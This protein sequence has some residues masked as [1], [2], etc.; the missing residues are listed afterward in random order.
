MEPQLSFPSFSLAGR[1]AL[2]TGAARGIG[3]AL[4]LGLAQAGAQVAVTDLNEADLQNVVAEIEALGGSTLAR[5][6]DVRQVSTIGPAFEACGHA[7]GGL[8]I[9][10]N[11]AGIEKVCDSL[12]VDQ[13]LWDAILN[14]NLRGAFFCAQAAGRMMARTGGGAMVNLC[15]LTSS[16]GV[17]TAVPYTSSKSGLLG[18][19]RALAAEW[20]PKGIRVNGI[21]PG[22]FRTQLTEVFYQDEAW[23]QS[24]LSKIPMGRFGHVQDLI[25]TTVFLC[26]QAAAYITGQLITIDGGYLAAI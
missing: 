15:S 6:I 3:R 26:S 17:P 13:E 23:C 20:A 10:V 25:G 5:A 4:A 22:Y 18:M 8:D 24:M 16:V 7:L 1:K 2:V 9:L 21:A 19:T 12:E 11:N 14:T